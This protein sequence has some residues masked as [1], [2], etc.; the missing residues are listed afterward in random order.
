MASKN[1]SEASCERVREWFQ[2]TGGTTGKSEAGECSG[3][4]GEPMGRG[5]K[6]SDTIE[7]P[8]ILYFPSYNDVLLLLK[9]KFIFCILG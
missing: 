8:L 5:L 9:Q 3:P 4:D 1:A 6:A 2:M 7:V